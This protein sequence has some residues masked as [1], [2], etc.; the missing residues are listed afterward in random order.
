MSHGKEPLVVVKGLRLWYYTR[1]GVYR[2]LNGVDLEVMRGEVLGL[3]GESGCGKSTLGL[4]MMGLLPR[5]AA[6]VDGQVLVDGLDVVAPLREYFKRAKR[7]RP[8]KNEDVLK[9]LHKKLMNLRGT[10]MTMVF[11]EPMTT[12]NPVLPV[13]YQI[14]EVVLQH[15]PGLLARRRLARARATK[16]DVRQALNF[17]RANDY[18]GLYSYLKSKGLEGL[19]D[20]LLGIWRRRDIHDLVKELRILSL[21]C[22]P[23]NPVMVPALQEVARANEL[24]L[25]PGVRQLVRREL[26]K[27]GY[28]KAAEFLGLL[29]MPEPE[30]VVRMYPHELSGGMRQRVVIATAMINNPDLVIL[31][32]PTSALDVTIQAQILELL[33]ELKEVSNAAFVFISHDLSVLYQVSDRVAIMYAGKVV[34]VGPRDAVFKEPRHPYTQML[35]EAVPTLE[36]HELKGIKGEVPDLRSP[37][38]GCMFHPRCPNAMPI[39]RERDPP[40]IDVGGGHRVACWLYAGGEGR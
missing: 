23:V 14:A 34:E 31:D 29:G 39:C 1:R 30:K 3:A 25:A 33:R 15:N 18:D 9:R 37:P 11:Q 22:D 35:L 20:Q 4:T 13:G 5:N 40:T 8:D 7:F 6:V 10:K 38:T 24:P 36:P 17:L 19:E 16:D 21:C 12:L 32:E 27:E 2:A 28:R 26:V